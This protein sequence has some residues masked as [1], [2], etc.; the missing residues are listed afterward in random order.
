M[1]FFLLP[2]ATIISSM[3][4]LAQGGFA[5]SCE[6][7]SLSGWTLTAQC[8][9]NS[10]NYVQSSLDLSK[11]LGWGAGGYLLCQPEE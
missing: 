2:V 10:G 9:T 7:T 8:K 11:C 5:S 6:D 1:R 3:I 4:E